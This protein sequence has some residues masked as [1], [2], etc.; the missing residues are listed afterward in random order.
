MQQLVASDECDRESLSVVPLDRYSGVI[1]QWDEHLQR[2][3]TPEPTDSRYETILKESQAA[4]AE[5]HG[6]DSSSSS[7]I[8]SLL[9]ALLLLTQ[10]TQLIWR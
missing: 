4:V 1:I 2:F 10:L 7:V 9:E 3:G 5:L 6:E 8:L